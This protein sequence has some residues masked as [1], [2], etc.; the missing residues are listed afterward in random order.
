LD[1]YGRAA[2]TALQFLMAFAANNAAGKLK[3]LT[4][5]LTTNFVGND[6]LLNLLNWKQTNRLWL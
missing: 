3:L 6:Y 4:G 2:V 1:G 5:I